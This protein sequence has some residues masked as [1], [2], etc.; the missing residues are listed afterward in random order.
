MEHSYRV[1]ILAL[2]L[3]KVWKMTI[4]LARTQMSFFTGFLRKWRKKK[5]KQVSSSYTWK[6]A[7]A[8][9]ICNL[10]VLT[11]EKWSALLPPKMKVP[12]TSNFYC[13]RGVVKIDSYCMTQSLYKW[14]ASQDHSSLSW[15][16]CSL[17]WTSRIIFLSMTFTGCGTRMRTPDS[18]FTNTPYAW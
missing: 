5:K 9:Q 6:M 3:F 10:G 15:K 18:A 12:G 7:H 13:T 14:S 16:L 8:M 1:T 4:F 2:L 17:H 11:R